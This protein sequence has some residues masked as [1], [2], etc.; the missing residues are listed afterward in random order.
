MILTFITIFN[1]IPHEAVDHHLKQVI[2]IKN[3][4]GKINIC[5]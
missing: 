4:V 3:K 1:N 5:L 2:Q